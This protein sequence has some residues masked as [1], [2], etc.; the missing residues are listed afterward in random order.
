M[1]KFLSNYSKNA[2]PLGMT[3]VKQN[4]PGPISNDIINDSFQK[5]E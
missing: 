5:L 4:L 2:L 3:A 1:N